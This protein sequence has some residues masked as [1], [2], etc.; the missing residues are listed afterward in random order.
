[1]LAAA[2]AER[3][4]YVEA[5]DESRRGRQGKLGDGRRKKRERAE[6]GQV[7]KQ[8]N[9]NFSPGKGTEG[10]GEVESGT[11][12]GGGCSRRTVAMKRD[13]GIERWEL[14]AGWRE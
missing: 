12:I 6:D 2:G 9:A 3:L 11:N 4:E 7:S 1:M 8:R 13:D 10:G 14:A 5:G